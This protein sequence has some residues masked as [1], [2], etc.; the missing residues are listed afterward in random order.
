VLLV[1]SRESFC[2]PGR[3]FCLSGILGKVASRCLYLVAKTVHVGV[4]VDGL[5]NP[6]QWPMVH[7]R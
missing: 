7:S 2:P 1:S 4:D 3:S 5:G 6:L